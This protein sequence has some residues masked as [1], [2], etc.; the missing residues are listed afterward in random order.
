MNKRFALI[1]FGNEES[2]GL[3]FVG[4]DLKRLGHE[5]K[6]F[7]GEE[8]NVSQRVIAWGPDY[9]CFSPMTAF[10]RSALKVCGQIKKTLPHMVSAFGGHHAMSSPD[11]IHDEG[12]DV[13][14]VG[15]A[16]G[17]LERILK[18][19][20]GVLSV[21]PTTPDDM[22]MPARDEYY[23]DI[24][25][26]TRRYR[27]FML[28]TLGC[29]WNCSYCSS[30]AGHIADIFGKETQRRY[31]LRRRP[32]EQLMQEAINIVKYETHEI[33]WVD[34]DIFYGA[35]TEEW[36]PTFVEAWEREIKVPI[37]VS[38]TSVNTL[39]V[40]D[41]TL[42]TLKRIVNCVGIGIQALRPESL[43]IFNRAWDNEAK[44]KA[45]YDRLR[46][47][48]YAVNLQCIIGLPVRDP[49][50]DALD[51]IKGMQRIGP[52]SVVSCYPL[53]V[54]PGTAMHQ[55]CVAH[56]IPLNDL[57]SGDTNTGIPSI[58]F[59]PGVVKQLR[60]VCK[61]ATVFV[62]F[63][64]DEKWMRALINIDMDDET[65]KHLSMTRYYECV[66]DR[67]PDKAGKIFTDVL[68]SMKLKY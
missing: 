46:S 5:F 26:M 4:G 25:R 52:G 37:Y 54:F 47:F 12:V 39:R 27:K 68:N 10:Y 56:K 19:E 24:P 1:S 67:L 61:L 3:L 66:T 7:D 64:I 16:C 59:P 53:I 51:T 55:Y 8:D 40:S 58:S 60:N 2:Y 29:P 63:N 6:F 49:V 28:S 42:R 57:C 50:D 34:D 32:L 36:I 31:Y 13:V 65:S 22:A 38:T 62:K 20:K 17:S 23:R 33:E 18:G 43:K 21:V 45:A 48:G 11:I 9:I 44:M 41:N 15:P 30:S 35:D 14:V